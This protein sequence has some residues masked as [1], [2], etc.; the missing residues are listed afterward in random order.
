[1]GSNR[2]H[3]V[4]VRGGRFRFFRC[5]FYLTFKHPACQGPRLHRPVCCAFFVP[6]F[7]FAVISLFCFIRLVRLL[8]FLIFFFFFCVLFLLFFFCFSFFS[9]FPFFFLAPFFI[10]ILAVSTIF[11]H[12]AACGFSST[13]RTVGSFL[14]AMI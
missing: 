5:G 8:F 2:D 11:R 12:N 1:M 14:P 4:S 7:R 10:S 3:P 6:Y 13:G 9:F